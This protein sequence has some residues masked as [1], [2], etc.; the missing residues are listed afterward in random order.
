[1]NKSGIHI[2][3]SHKGKLH[4]ALGVPAGKPVPAGKIE[5]ATHSSNP[6]LK[7]EAVFAKNARKWNH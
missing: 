7:K 5:K 2:K 1:M 4:E 3:P 6:T